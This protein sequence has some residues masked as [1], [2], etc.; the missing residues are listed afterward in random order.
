MAGKKNP[1]K[2]WRLLQVNLH[3]QDL[4]VNGKSTLL[5]SI[6]RKPLFLYNTSVTLTSQPQMIEIDSFV[7]DAPRSHE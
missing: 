2:R 3:Q 7:A 6:P 4:V 1:M 5:N